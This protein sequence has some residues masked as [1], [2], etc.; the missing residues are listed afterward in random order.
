MNK[1]NKN[2]LESY[3][4]YLSDEIYL[5]EDDEMIQS[6]GKEYIHCQL[7]YMKRYKVDF[8]PERM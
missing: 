8:R 4:Q 1:E 5:E 2:R 6:L 3:L 7:I